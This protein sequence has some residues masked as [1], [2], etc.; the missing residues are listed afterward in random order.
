MTAVTPRAKPVGQGAE[1]WG[2]WALTAVAVALKGSYLLEY[3][4]LPFLEGPIGDST[5]YVAQAAAVRE[6]RFGDP[7]LLAFSPLYGY[8]LAAFPNPAAVVLVQFALGIATLWLIYLGTKTRFG[9]RA[10]LI[11]AALYLGY[12]L[13]LFYETKVLSDALGLTLAFWAMLAFLGAKFRSGRWPSSLMTGALVGLSALARAS[14]VFGVPIFAAVSLF[15]WEASEGWSRRLQRT[16]G[17]VAGCAIVLGGYGFW[18]QAHSGVFVLVRY[19]TAS[20]S[21]LQNTTSRPWEADLA[22]VGFRGPGAIASAWDLVAAVEDDLARRRAT[23]DRAGQGPDRGRFRDRRRRL[24][25]RGTSKALDH[26]VRHGKDLSVRLLRGASSLATA[27]SAAGHVSCPA[28]A[29]NH[30]GV[31]PCSSGESGRTPAL[32][33]LVRWC[34]ADRHPLPSEQSLPIGHDR[35]ARPPWRFGSRAPDHEREGRA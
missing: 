24:A 22:D 33:S 12:G 2:I 17:M 32:P 6:G 8:L 18:T 28:R 11:S 7:T 10:G 5:V 4:S 34:A 1:R 35:S 31:L 25:L 16:A 19:V 29:W 30:R 23:D 27:P 9:W 26:P 21:N 20:T 14:L 13:V 3:A 15:R